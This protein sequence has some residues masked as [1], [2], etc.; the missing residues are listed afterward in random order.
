MNHFITT[1]LSTAQRI[2]DVNYIGTFL[3]SREASKLMRKGKNKRIINFTTIAAP[4]NLEGEA[5]YASS[6]AAVEKLTIIL[7][8]E[9]SHLGI[10]VNAVGPSSI[11]TL[12]LAGV[13]QEVKTQLLQKQT[14]KRMGTKEDV[15]NIVKFFMSKKSDF[16]TGQIIYMGGIS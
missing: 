16:I 15:Y 14:I 1:P 7:S 10:T 4:L 11:D 5:S 12:L 6:K 13:P 2:M 8:K 3:V 9:L